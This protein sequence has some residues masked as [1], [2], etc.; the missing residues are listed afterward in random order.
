MRH[1]NESGTWDDQ[2]LQVY[3]W[4]VMGFI[5]S[6][7]LRRN[8]EN[9]H[10]ANHVMLDE[11]W[12]LLRT[13][14]GAAAIENIARRSR[15]RRAALWMATQQIGEFLEKEHGRKILSVVGTKLLMGVSPFEAKR[16]RDP[17]E[18]ADYLIDTLTKLGYGEGMLQMANAVLKVWIRTPKELGLY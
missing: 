5:W 12:S 7:V 4:Q 15:K 9:P 18:L 17:F 6:E 1:V 16:M 8:A 10:I 11:V 13:P 14:G 3:L 2:E